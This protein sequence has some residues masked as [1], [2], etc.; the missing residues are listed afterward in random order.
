MASEWSYARIWVM[1]RSGGVAL[2]DAVGK[3]DTGDAGLFNPSM[4]SVTRSVTL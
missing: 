2:L 3:S 1:G 4:T